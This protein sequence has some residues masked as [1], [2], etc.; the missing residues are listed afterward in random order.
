[1]SVGTKARGVAAVLR[2]MR[3]SAAAGSGPPRIS[4]EREALRPACAQGY[5]RPSSRA[6]L[7]RAAC[8]EQPDQRGYGLDSLMGWGAG[9]AGSLQR[10]PSGP[11]AAQAKGTGSAERLDFVSTRCWR[12]TRPGAVTAAVRW[13]GESCPGSGLF[14]PVAART[15]PPTCGLDLAQRDGRT[16]RQPEPG[17]LPGLLPCDHPPGWDSLVSCGWPPG[18]LGEGH[19]LWQS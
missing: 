8:S 5:R 1:M 12:P 6:S 19:G 16:L 18:Y 4:G 9:R 13:N 3:V 14:V 17:L 15:S 7:F 11:A 2:P 10:R